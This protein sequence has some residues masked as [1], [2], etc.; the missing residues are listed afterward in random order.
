MAV[1]QSSRRFD[2]GLLWTV[3]ATAIAIVAWRC[4]WLCLSCLLIFLWALNFSSRFSRLRNGSS[5][6]YQNSC[7]PTRNKDWRAP[8]FPDFSPH[9][10]AVPAQQVNIWIPVGDRW[11]DIDA[12]NVTDKLIADFPPFPGSLETSVSS[13]YL[14]RIRRCLDWEPCG[15][16]FFLK[17]V[18]CV[19]I[20]PHCRHG[21]KL[22]GNEDDFPSLCLTTN[23]RRISQSHLLHIVLAP[24]LPLA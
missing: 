3:A 10:N 5:F 7:L 13:L 24:P 12:C 21:W 1:W 16:S 4:L 6:L 14:P 22:Y 8:D 9:S 20:F 23:I 18:V 17:L 2:W 15:R 19:R 11:S